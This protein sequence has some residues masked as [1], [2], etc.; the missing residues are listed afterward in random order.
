MWASSVFPAPKPQLLDVAVQRSPVIRGEVNVNAIVNYSG[1]R[2]LKV[3]LQKNDTVLNIQQV[4]LNGQNDLVLVIEPDEKHA[5]GLSLRA[6]SIKVDQNAVG[7]S[8]SI[9]ILLRRIR[10][11]ILRLDGALPS[12]KQLVGR[13]D[14]KVE[15]SASA[16]D[17]DIRGVNLG[18]V[19]TAIASRGTGARLSIAD[20]SF[21]RIRI[22]GSSPSDTS[23]QDY[24]PI[25]HLSIDAVP[26]VRSN[27]LS[28]YGSPPSIELAALDIL[29]GEVI[30]KPARKQ[31][32]GSSL[33]TSMAN[34]FVLNL[35]RVGIATGPG[36][37]IT[38]SGLE[39]GK[40]TLRIRAPEVP[41]AE[42][43]LDELTLAGTLR[44]N[45]R[46]L[47]KL[48][49]GRIKEDKDSDISAIEITASSLRR[50]WFGSVSVGKLALD[51]STAQNSYKDE[52]SELGHFGSLR[53]SRTAMLP[54]QVLSEITAQLSSSGSL[55]FQ[56]KVAIRQFLRDIRTTGFYSDTRQP[57][58]KDV[59]FNVLSIDA[60]TFYGPVLKKVLIW[61]TGLGVRLE[62]PIMVFVAFS[63][64]FFAIVSVIWGIGKTGVSFRWKSYLP[65]Y[66]AVISGW[67]KES[68]G[69]M[70][71]WVRLF[72]N[73][74]R[75]T[76]AL[77]IT[78][79]GLFIQ[80]A[81]L[82]GL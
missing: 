18:Q 66:L 70:S 45:F 75:L 3:R 44:A 54:V 17:V 81:V 80:N 22:F 1:S 57:V 15:D 56:E 71:P 7:N 21:E 47:N 4:N 79:V 67:D 11:A 53:I 78:V 63:V 74:H 58:A 9:S 27:N 10:T 60:E 73:L 64:T 36:E 23:K 20:A 31:D 28:L 62:F 2:L 68:L 69:A 5:Q 16:S 61:S 19:S 37:K 29:Q 72:V 34:R 50:I 30:L 82:A 12:G 33:C 77:Q 8:G 46:E 14:L 41:C 39:G 38:P 42:V 13:V 49:L 48:V 6:I 51:V 52:R 26:V 55:P 40:G 25:A 76:I 43:T 65:K 35:E 24:A 59:L 32:I